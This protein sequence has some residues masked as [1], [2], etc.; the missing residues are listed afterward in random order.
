MHLTRC[1]EYATFNAPWKS[2]TT[3]RTSC[4]NWLEMAMPRRKRTDTE[5]VATVSTP[6]AYLTP[7]QRKRLVRMM[8]ETL[9]VSLLDEEAGDQLIARIDDLTAIL[10]AS[11][12]GLANRATAFNTLA[13]AI[14][15]ENFVSF[16]EMV[17][18]PGLTYHREQHMHL[19]RT[20]PDRRTL[21]WCY[22]HEYVLIPGPPRPMNLYDIFTFCGNALCTVQE[23]WWVRD[24]ESFPTA[25]SV[26][27]RWIMHRAY[28][29]PEFLPLHKQMAQLCNG[30]VVPNAAETLWACIMFERL[31]DIFLLGNL[32]V[33]TSSVDKHGKRVTVQRL[34]AD[35]ST[36]RYSVLPGGDDNQGLALTS[37]ATSRATV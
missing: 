24:Q 3:I 29:G 12:I 11:M 26:S 37:L 27:C 33:R 19:E 21:E 17:V 15:G 10:E 31:R 9:E 30:E 7:L 14:L 8:S 5:Q 4:V 36:C 16:E 20:L 2:R 13:S 1:Q 23:R 18:I 35:G 28:P 22:H 34:D 32:A 25:D 6:S